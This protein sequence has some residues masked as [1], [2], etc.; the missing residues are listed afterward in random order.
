MN[1]L[2]IVL[3]NFGIFDESY[4]KISWE[5]VALGKR[6]YAERG[7]EQNK[8]DFSNKRMTY[9]LGISLAAVSLT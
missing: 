6:A 9:M 4:R 8:E 7:P 1:F 5:E 3:R 2:E